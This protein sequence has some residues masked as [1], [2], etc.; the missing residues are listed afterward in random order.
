ML[1]RIHDAF[2]AYWILTIRLRLTYM[3]RCCSTRKNVQFCTKRSLRHMLRWYV[4][5]YIV[6]HDRDNE[7]KAGARIRLS[8]LGKQRCPR[9]KVHTGIIVGRINRADAFR[10][11]FD[12][13]KVPVTFH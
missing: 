9:I 5:E 7:L 4:A 8:A 2:H 1:E 11:L 10:I 13:R 12:G 3:Q 6:G